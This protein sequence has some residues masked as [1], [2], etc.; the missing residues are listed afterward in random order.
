MYV[1]YMNVKNADVFREIRS[2]LIE[3][4]K[5]V[6]I[7]RLNRLV[8]APEI[9]VKPPRYGYAR[10]FRKRAALRASIEVPIIAS[11]IMGGHK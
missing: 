7:C 8:R 5:T 3:P 2:H 10:R 11:A 4:R 6:N 1:G 9:V